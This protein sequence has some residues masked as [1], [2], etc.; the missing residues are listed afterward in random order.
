MRAVEIITVYLACAAPFGVARF[1]RFPGGVRGRRIAYAAAAGLLWPLILLSHFTTRESSARGITPMEKNFS[2]P[3]AKFRRA[4]RALVEALY[5][6]EDEAVEACGVKSS[7]PTA[8]SARFARAAVERYAGLTL[9][10][11]RARRR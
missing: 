9:A 5:Q 7:E 10:V 8:Q 4:E 2:P 3:D 6:L 1:L 11:C